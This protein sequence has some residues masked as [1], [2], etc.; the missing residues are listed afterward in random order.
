MGHATSPPVICMSSACQTYTGHSGVLMRG[1]RG[2]GAVLTEI[3]LGLGPCGELRY[4]AYQVTRVACREHSL[5]EE[6]KIGLG[7]TL[8]LC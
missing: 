6:G 7:H 3:C 1:W 4:P 2:A 8:L 5:L